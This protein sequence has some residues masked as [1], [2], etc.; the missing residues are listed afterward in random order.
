[1][2]QFTGKEPMLTRDAL[3][4]ASHPMFFSSDKARS[5]FGYTARPYR[6]GLEDALA[7]FRAEGYLG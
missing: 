7:W 4:M 1:V 6:A 5:E 3:R 2:A